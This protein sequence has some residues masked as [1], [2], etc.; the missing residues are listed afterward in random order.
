L[1]GHLVIFVIPIKRSLTANHLNK[2]ACSDEPDDHAQYDSGRLDLVEP[3]KCPKRIPKKDNRRNLDQNRQQVKNTERIILGEDFGLDSQVIR[4]LDGFGLGVF[5]FA[6]LDIFGAN[7]YGVGGQFVVNEI[8]QILD[9][10][11]SEIVHRVFLTDAK[12]LD[13]SRNHLAADGL[14][15]LVFS[16]FY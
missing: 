15:D 13:C 5:D 9:R 3:D 4:N 10:Q 2:T 6:F 14:T 16:I 1:F 12:R 11:E 7:M 8:G